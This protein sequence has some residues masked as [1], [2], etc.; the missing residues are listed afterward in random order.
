MI[1]IG[2]LYHYFECVQK[3][4]LKDELKLAIAA[5]EDRGIHYLEKVPSDH[6]RI[7]WIAPDGSVLYDTVTGT[8]NRENHLERTE[9]KSAFITGEG[10]AIVILILYLK[11]QCIMQNVWKMVQY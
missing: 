1:I 2:C 4:N 8:A 3:N 5:V 7:T 10:K 9:I 11:K 6:Y